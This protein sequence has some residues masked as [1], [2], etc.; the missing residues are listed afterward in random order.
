MPTD[1]PQPEQAFIAYELHPQTDYPLEPAPISR[2]WMD[3]AHQRG[4]RDQQRQAG[5]EDKS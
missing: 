2:D 4:K 1:Q 5:L 3:K